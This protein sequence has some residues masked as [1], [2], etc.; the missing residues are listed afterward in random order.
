MAVG[1]L[2]VSFQHNNCRAMDALD[3]K[4]PEWNFLT[5]VDIAALAVNEA[6]ICHPCCQ[7]WLTNRFHGNFHIK[8][9]NWGIVTIPTSFKIVL[10]A[11]FLLPMYI[12]IQ[13][14]GN[15]E[16]SVAET[17]EEGE[18]DD[19]HEMSSSRVMQTTHASQNV[20]FSEEREAN[21]SLIRPKR[22]IG[23]KT[24]SWIMRP[25]AWHKKANWTKEK[26]RLWYYRRGPQPPLHWKVYYMWSA[27][28]TKFW[29]FQIMYILF[30][31][32]FSY[33]V[34]LPSCGD[35]VLDSVLV[36]WTFIILADVIRRVYI[37]SQQ[38]R[39]IPVLSKC[40]E[41]VL[42]MFFIVVIVTLR[43]F[44][45][46]FVIDLFPAPKTVRSAYTA[47]VIMCIA[48]LYFYFRLM[49]VYFPISPTLGPLLYR[50][51]LMVM[52][53]FMNFMRLAML[54]I[55][56][57]GI[58]IHAVIYPDYPMGKELLRRAFHRTVFSMFLTFIA[59]L[60]VNPDCPAISSKYSEEH[61]TECHMGDSPS[62][63]CQTTGIWPYVMSLQYLVIM[64]LI[65]LTLIYAMFSNTQMEKA[66]D[67]DVI[68]K[69]QRYRLV[70]DFYTRLPLPPPL[71]V[72]CYLF[73]FFKYVYNCCCCRYSPCRKKQEVKFT[74]YVYQMRLKIN[75]YNY[76]RAAAAE[77]ISIQDAIERKKEIE[78]EQLERLI[79]LCHNADIQMQSMKVIKG[80][81][82]ELEKNLQSC[83][84]ALEDI[85]HEFVKSDEKNLTVHLNLLS[86]QSPYPGT[87]VQRFLIADKYVPWVVL[88]STY[89][90]VVYTKPRTDYPTHVRD[91]VDEDILLLRETQ[92]PHYKLPEMM[93][94]IGYTSGGGIAI[95]RT[96][97]MTAE[98][99]IRS[100]VRV[101]AVAGR[102]C[103]GDLTTPS[104]L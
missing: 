23:P 36:G 34:L 40:L 59:D 44:K 101:C 75:D 12:W 22:V 25:K 2:E 69:F 55:I 49:L 17:D 3:E 24:S 85:Q 77:F 73:L 39:S 41:I 64:K 18:I 100:D 47:R 15:H 26:P 19:D 90:P 37:Q 81:I 102:C 92:A 80:A 48:L 74:D 31:A 58:V 83:R 79:A 35:Y 61:G 32:F 94:N 30:L 16:L 72:F 60:E 46:P 29:T 14:Y 62:Y 78:K 33:V 6:F 65:L 82:L 70:V 13:F 43:I 89:D 86:R 96:S 103:A 1:V 95:D 50:M 98:N 57:S 84:I 38:F 27:P 52:I 8:E 76:W 45:I 53:D 66:A 71:N 10:S 7:K 99:E 63:K 42:V 87:K 104:I 67:S 97:W 91:Y 93:W 21:A 4:S 9:I 5:A 11:F 68:W 28:I 20:V 51:K 54:I 88:F 56:S